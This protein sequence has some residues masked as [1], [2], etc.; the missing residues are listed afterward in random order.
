MGQLVLCFQ[1]P[2]NLREL[3]PILTVSADKNFKRMKYLE[4][5]GLHNGENLELLRLKKRD[6]GSYP[7][8]L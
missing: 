7:S 4:E 2:L 5:L 3:Y 1:M 8:S 6:G